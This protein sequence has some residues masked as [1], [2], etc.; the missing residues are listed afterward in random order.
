MKRDACA[1]YWAWHFGKQ[2]LNA[3]GQ[4]VHPKWNGS[5]TAA[6]IRTGAQPQYCNALGLEAPPTLLAAADEVI[7]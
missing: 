4:V 3:G 2:T 6:Q 7:E 5:R 1:L